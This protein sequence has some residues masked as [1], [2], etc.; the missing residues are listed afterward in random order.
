MN[1][2]V[3][4]VCLCRTIKV[5]LLDSFDSKFLVLKS[6]LIRIWSKSTGVLDDMVGKGG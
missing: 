2:G 6:N 3:K 1:Q 4:F 5:Q